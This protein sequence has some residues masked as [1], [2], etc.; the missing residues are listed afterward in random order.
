MST[1]GPIMIPKK[2]HYIWIGGKKEPEI[3][4]KCLNSWKKY[5]P[6]YEIIRWDES[7]IDFNI[8]LF[9]KIAYE[10]GKLAHTGDYLRLHILH[11]YGG[12]YLDVDVEII[13]PFT[14]LLEY[15]AFFSFQDHKRINTGNGFGSI[16]GNKLLRSIMNEYDMISKNGNFYK[17]LKTSPEVDTPI[18]KSL[19]LI[20]NN[21]LQIINNCIFLPKDFMSPKSFYSNR[22]YLTS[23]T[24]SIHH[25]DG[26]WTS[27]KNFN[28]DVLFFILPA[29]AA[30]LVILTIEKFKLLFQKI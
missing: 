4:E 8:S 9:T 5:C 26:S 30:E 23:N 1:L 24:I 16:Q 3:F 27:D 17:F 22:I 6:D 14:Q 18:L 10:H 7:N 2:L 12:I 25:F 28:Y 20:P 11:S 21:R 13:K 19:G 15:D 29:K